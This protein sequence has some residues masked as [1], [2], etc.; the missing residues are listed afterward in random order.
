MNNQK[1]CGVPFSGFSL[2][3]DDP[4]DQNRVVASVCCHTWLNPPYSKLK[5]PVSEDAN[6]FLDITSFWNSKEM[7][8]FRKSIADG[9]YAFC[10]KKSC[11]TYQS[12][13]F[14]P[15]PEKA[16]GLIEQGIY[17][18]DYP[19]LF[20]QASVDRSCNLSCPS[21]R[22]APNYK[23]NPKSY[24][25]LKSILANDVELILTNGTGE[26]FKNRYLLDALNE[27]GLDNY[28]HLKHLDILTNGTLLSRTMW[29]SLS[30]GF[31]SRIRLISVSVDAATEET[32]KKIR[33]GG[34]FKNLIQ[35]LH[36]ISSLRK[37]NKIPQ[38]SMSFVAQKSNIH[39]ILDFV[40]LAK[41]IG[42][43]GVGITRVENWGVHNTKSFYEKLALPEDWKIT[44]K[45]KLEE[46]EKFVK[47]NN[48]CYYTNI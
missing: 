21:C 35:N 2:Y 41:D 25:W 33:V 38:F 40:K 34:N 10:N 3:V 5:K 1:I 39:E 11:P 13:D 12:K 17:E 8:N 26:L 45:D 30:D 19:P 16:K 24:T 18:V 48:L 23:S 27:I 36:F 42:V 31:K 28:P 7:V 37:E 32:Y 6:G 14:A 47:D 22:N 4:F 46:V 15:L 44:Y 20:I 43:D 29:A 9:S